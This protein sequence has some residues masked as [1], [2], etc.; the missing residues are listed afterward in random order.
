MSQ[1]RATPEAEVLKEVWNTLR[2]EWVGEIRE[3]TAMQR[4]ALLA[5]D[6]WWA[7]RA[8][9]SRSRNPDEPAIA[10]LIVSLARGEDAG[11][12]Q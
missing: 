10:E 9:D 6:G 3:L 2:R 1:V 12:R 7:N 5:V 4:V 11:G 8:V